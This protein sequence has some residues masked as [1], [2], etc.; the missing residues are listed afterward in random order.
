VSSLYRFKT[1]RRPRTD[2]GRGWRTSPVL[3]VIDAL[4]VRPGQGLFGLS[5]S[6]R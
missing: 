1:G 5:R 6:G 2:A 3:L 4:S